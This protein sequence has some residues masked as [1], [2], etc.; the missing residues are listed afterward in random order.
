MTTFDIEP[1]EYP[2]EY[3]G[4]VI[5]DE[6]KVR[7]LQPDERPDLSLVT[8]QSR[9]NEVL[10]RHDIQYDNESIIL[11]DSYGA[12]LVG[13]GEVWG[14]HKSVPYLNDWAVLLVKDDE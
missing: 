13:G 9:V 5:H 10:D 6:K 7:D 12:L 3:R 4:N 14:I 1:V 2:T 8:G 11:E